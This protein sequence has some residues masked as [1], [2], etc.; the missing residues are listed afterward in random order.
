MSSETPSSPSIKPQEIFK[1]K[2]CGDCCIGYG[3][4]YVTEENIK[5]I[6]DYIGIDSK[7]FINEKCQMSGGRPVLAQGE[8]GYCVFWDNACMIYPVRP[9]M[10]IKWPF[11][12]SVLRDIDNWNIMAG[13]CPGIRVDISDSAIIECVRQE[14]SRI[15]DC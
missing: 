12:E 3:G 9:L 10:C 11:I 5:T 14:L 15:A 1:C 13:L 6:A 2:K 8:N 4:T 7:R